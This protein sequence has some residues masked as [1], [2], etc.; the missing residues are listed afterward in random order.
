MHSIY[1]FLHHFPSLPTH[2]QHFHYYQHLPHVSVAMVH[3]LT[4]EVFPLFDMMRWTIYLLLS[5]FPLSI[6]WSLR[7]FGFDP[8]TAASG[9]LVASLVGTDFANLG[10]PYFRAYGGL[11][12]T[13]YIFQGWG[14][15]S[16]LWAMVVLPPALSV[17]YQV[18]RTGQGYFWATLLLSITLMSHLLYVYMAFLTLG[19]L[20]LIPILQLPNLKSVAPSTNPCNRKATSSRAFLPLW[21]SDGET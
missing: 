16:Q 21:A 5:M 15:Y 7:R 10:A 3:V 14:L 11:G 12:Q 6:Y 18:M 13:S 19:A 17:G 2:Y 8:L 1:T 20:T 9:G 4:L